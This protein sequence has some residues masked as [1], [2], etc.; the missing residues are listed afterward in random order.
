MNQPPRPTSSPQRQLNPMDYYVAALATPERP[1]AL[2]TLGVVS[3]IVAV[4]SLLASGFTTFF[5]WT[6]F[7]GSLPPRPRLRLRPSP[8][9]RSRTTP[10][11]RSRPTV[12]PAR[13]A[14]PWSPGL[15]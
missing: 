2:I 3:L 7:R 4:L 15:L 9:S 10:A 11:K 8:R 13:S 5:W 6:G 1:G 14:R 12:F